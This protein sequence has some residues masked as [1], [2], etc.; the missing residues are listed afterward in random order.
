M[1]KYTFDSLFFGFDKW[2]QKVFNYI[3]AYMQIVYYTFC[4][5]L[6]MKGWENGWEILWL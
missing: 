6:L 2:L 3:I 5:R 1:K 4:N